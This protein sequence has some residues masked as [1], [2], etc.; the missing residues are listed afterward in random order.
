MASSCRFEQIRFSQIIL[1]LSGS[2]TLCIDLDNFMARLCSEALMFFQISC[3]VLV[4]MA[5]FQYDTSEDM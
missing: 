4:I 1:R 2:L 5:L 3:C